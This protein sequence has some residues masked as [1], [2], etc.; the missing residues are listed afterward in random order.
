[1]GDR[2]EYKGIWAVEVKKKKDSGMKWKIFSK[3][4]L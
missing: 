2:A 1:M 4:N 3:Q